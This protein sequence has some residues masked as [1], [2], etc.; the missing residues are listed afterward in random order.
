MRVRM[1]T[2]IFFLWFIETRDLR[3]PAAHR[4]AI[5]APLKALVDII[6]LMSIDNSLV[7]KVYQAISM[8]IGLISMNYQ[9]QK[10]FLSV[11]YCQY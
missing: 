6:G 2:I 3:L 1:R 10:I 7:S 5:A 4:H 9:Y 8:A 11:C